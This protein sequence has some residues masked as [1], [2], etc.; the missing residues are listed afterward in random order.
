MGWAQ[1]AEK[2]AAQ[3]R[4]HQVQVDAV[5]ERLKEAK[6]AVAAANERHRGGGRRFIRAPPTATAEG[7]KELDKAKLA[8]EVAQ[9]EERTAAVT[10]HRSLSGR[11]T[12][13]SSSAS[14]LSTAGSFRTFSSG[15]P[16]AASGAAVSVSQSGLTRHKTHGCVCVSSAAQENQTLLVGTH[17]RK[18]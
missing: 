11:L 18:M 4:E 8:L 15:P 17:M 10:A 16:V 12:N 9:A 1:V 3:F 2:A 13:A 7:R 5:Q 6:A 14:V